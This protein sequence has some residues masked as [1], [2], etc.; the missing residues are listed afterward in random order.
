[1][2]GKLNEIVNPLHEAARRGNLSFIQECITRK[3]SPT[4]LDS[5]GNT[6]LYWASHSGHAE[7]VNYLLQLPDPPLN[8]QV[9]IKCL[10]FIHLKIKLKNTTLVLLL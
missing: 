2:E 7:C 9:N 10:F 8:A 6:A 4:G 1:M 5:M 3:V